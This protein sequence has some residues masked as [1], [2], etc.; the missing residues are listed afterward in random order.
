[1]NQNQKAQRYDELLTQ[2]KRIENQIELVP[3]LSLDETLQDIYSK[4]YTPENQQTVNRL[5]N[6][7]RQID[8][9]VKRLF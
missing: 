4:E 7:L 9:E 5:T 6:Q 2:Y 1:M 3:K 8:E